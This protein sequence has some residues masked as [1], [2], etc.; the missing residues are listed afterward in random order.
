MK[1]LPARAYD[2]AVYVVFS[3]P[4]GMDDDQLKNGH[5]M[6]L[7]PFGDVISECTELEDQIV[8]ALCTPT[9]LQLA[10]GSRYKMA[11]RPSLYR[12]IIGKEHRPEL[13]VNWLEHGNQKE[14]TE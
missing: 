12:D 8:T 14:D 2:N 7:D 1:W 6:V 9:K 13:R 10:G 11:R 4:I 5:S 3:N